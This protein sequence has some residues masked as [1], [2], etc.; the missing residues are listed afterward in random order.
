MVLNDRPSLEVE[1]TRSFRCFYSQFKGTVIHGN[2]WGFIFSTLLT[3]PLTGK[4]QLRPRDQ[5]HDR[6]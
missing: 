1:N 5:K 3:S 6:Q 4:N 2:R